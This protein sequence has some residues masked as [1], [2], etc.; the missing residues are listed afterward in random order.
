MDDKSQNEVSD[1][2]MDR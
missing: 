1:Y 2:F